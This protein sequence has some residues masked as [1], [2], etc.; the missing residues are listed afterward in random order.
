MLL[1][2][3]L[4]LFRLLHY[5]PLPLLLQLGIILF[6][7]LHLLLELALL[8]SLED[9]S[10]PLIISLPSHSL[11]QLVFSLTKVLPRL[12]KLSSQ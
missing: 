8:L 4:I 9:S 5:L 12:I 2:Q 3:L 10:L 7:D 6:E 11:I 1:L